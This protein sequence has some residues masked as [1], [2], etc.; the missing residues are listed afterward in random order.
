MEPILLTSDG[1]EDMVRAIDG[2]KFKVLNTRT[3]NWDVFV[4]ARAPSFTERLSTYMSPTQATV[5]CHSNNN[6][7]LWLAVT[8]FGGTNVLAFDNKREKAC[9]LS[10]AQDFYKGF[11]YPPETLWADFTKKEVFKLFN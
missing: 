5:F 2:T 7:N 9:Y 10:R 4:T 3:N 6:P 11:K 8:R 1:I